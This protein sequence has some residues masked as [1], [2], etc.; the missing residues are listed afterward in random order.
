MCKVL[1][2]SRSGYY[3]WRDRKPSARAQRRI[4]IGEQARLFH[5][6]S[7]EIYGYRKVHADILAEA[8]DLACSRETLRKI[9]A[10]LGLVSRVKRRSVRTT[11]SQHRLPVAPNTL[12]RDFSATGPDQK[13]VA[14]I[15]YIRTLKGTL[16]LAG[17]MDLWSCR[18]VG[19]SMRG[20][21]N[22]DL[23]CDALGA[24]LLLRCPGVGL[25][26]H[27]DQGVQYASEAFQALLRQYSIECSMSRKGNCWDNAS[28]ES[29][30]GKLKTEWIQDRIYKTHEEAKQDI[31]YYIEV[32]YNRQ[33]RH[34]S[35][36]Y[37]APVEFEAGKSGEQ[38][39]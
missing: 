33:R 32:F 17:I 13:W 25:L 34:A 7:K 24:A 28:K 22:A 15:T 30:F 5:T 16:Y 11:D 1:K 21:I 12:N 39:A 35:L 2:V 23:V 38:V 29:F 19:W 26:H 4:A 20:R 27:S 8:R 31:F 14:D 3:D 18:I 9:M 36:G 37:V 10:E 6:R